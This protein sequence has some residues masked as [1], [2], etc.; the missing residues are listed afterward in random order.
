MQDEGAQIAAL[1][2]GTKP[3]M[4]V[5]DYCAGAGG[6]SLVIGG[7]MENKGRVLALD[8]SEGRLERCGVRTRRAGLHN[9]ERHVL[10][11]GSD[12]R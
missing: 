7:L 6:K 8:I 10:A 4:Q 12:R 3:G 9:I 11:E 5:A 2:L 1:L